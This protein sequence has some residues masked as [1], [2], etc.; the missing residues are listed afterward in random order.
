MPLSVSE[1]W[2]TSCGSYLS[3]VIFWPP[4]F[5]FL[6][7]SPLSPRVCYCK[8]YASYSVWM[9][10]IFCCIHQWLVLHACR[11][12]SSLVYCPLKIGIDPSLKAQYLESVM[13]SDISLAICDMSHKH[14][15]GKMELSIISYM[16]PA[17]RSGAGGGPVKSRWDQ[18]ARNGSWLDQNVR[19]AWSE[20]TCPN[21]P[22]HNIVAHVMNVVCQ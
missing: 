20:L 10:R 18:T 1:T 15:I 2:H 5:F 14:V 13:L 7:L 9:Y 8:L 21:T 22:Q 16:I 19:G 3:K 12:T 6:S 11:D 4:G 17:V